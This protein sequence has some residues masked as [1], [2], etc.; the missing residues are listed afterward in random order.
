MTKPGHILLCLCLLLS[1]EHSLIASLNRYVQTAVNTDSEGLV[2]DSQGAVIHMLRSS[3]ADQ[4]TITKTDSEG[5]LVTGFGTGG[6][7]TLNFTPDAGI[8]SVTTV[9]AFG[10]TG[11]DRTQAS[12]IGL[13]PSNRILLAVNL[14][15]GGDRS[16][17]IIRLNGT[18]GQLDE[19]YGS[20]GVGIWSGISA[21]FKL[22]G[23]AIDTTGRAIIALWHQ[24]NIAEVR[25]FSANGV[26]EVVAFDIMSNVA[27]GLSI[28]VGSLNDIYIAGRSGANGFCI[29]LIQ[30]TFLVDASFGT[31]GAYT[32]NLGL[33]ETSFVYVTVAAG[34]IYLL[35]LHGNDTNINLRTLNSVGALTGNQ[36][37]IFPSAV[38]LKSAVRTANGKFYLG[39]TINSG[40]QTAFWSRFTPNLGNLD[41]DLT[42]ADNTDANRIANGIMRVPVTAGATVASGAGGLL[43]YNVTTNTVAVGFKQT[44][45]DATTV[46]FVRDFGT[47]ADHFLT[48]PETPIVPSA[49]TSAPRFQAQNSGKTDAGFNRNTFG[50]SNVVAIEDAGV[51]AN[52]SD[53]IISYLRSG[54]NF[55]VSKTNED[56]S[57]DTSFGSN[58]S[59]SQLIKI[60][61]TGSSTSTVA[62]TNF[63][64]LTTGKKSFIGYNL[65]GSDAYIYIAFQANL[66][67]GN[68]QIVVIRLHNTTGLLDS[69]FGT[70]GVA[71][72]ADA[73]FVHQLDALAVDS[74]GRVVV[75][76]YRE[77]SGSKFPVVYRFT[78][79]GTLDGAF[80]SSGVKNLSAVMAGVTDTVVARLDLKLDTS[81]NIYV[82]GKYAATSPYGLFGVKLNASDGAIDNG[83][84]SSGRFTTGLLT[85]LTTTSRV[86]ASIDEY[87]STDN[88]QLCSQVTGGVLAVQ[89]SLA[90]QAQLA[91]NNNNKTV[92]SIPNITK[93]NFVQ[94]NDAG[95]LSCAGTVTES[96]I[97]KVFFA[98][99]TKEGVLDTTYGDT[100]GAVK[101]GTTLFTATG[102]IIQDGGWF[103]IDTGDAAPIVWIE[104]DGGTRRLILE[105]IP[106]N[107][108]LDS[109]TPTTSTTLATD[110]VNHQQSYM[111]DSSRLYANLGIAR[112]LIELRKALDGDVS[113]HLT[114]TVKDRAV[115][116][117][118]EA[119]KIILQAKISSA[120]SNGLRSGFK[121][122]HKTGSMN[123][124]M[125]DKTKSTANFTSNEQAAIAPHIAVRMNLIFGQ[126]DTRKTN[127]TGEITSN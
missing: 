90:G 95:N 70:A 71:T 27:S 67:T 69:G 124:Q 6:V 46:Q 89:F 122:K 98:R 25:R 107:D 40:G 44:L 42:F 31:A 76:T 72:I 91:F 16:I 63:T 20:G 30:G 51:L 112:H 12:Y 13:D 65:Y 28:A 47:E 57:L 36:N 117:F 78:D 81:N 87:P 123:K 45:S 114:T 38:V 11:L 39:G 52:T 58:Y 93:L 59:G 110:L 29:K 77:D 119:I 116:L 102:G 49:A 96:G 23:L 43:A 4:F 22:Q 60:R 118:D 99:I 53:S 35:T 14:Q 113:P 74:T 55:I 104:Q 3:T 19:T 101:T 106:T 79:N 48:S 34:S 2:V 24:S 80:G 10:L 121:E 84:G 127:V 82:V 62:I 75:L 7:V 73:N 94:R 17:A 21:S 105:R 120:S 32:A 8:S 88:I 26:A 5:S 54:D 41:N 15:F 56:G 92:V 37:G 18:T 111:L 61:A 100:S 85:E 33:D 9:R 68:K 86:F 125:H 50:G 64:G 103:S 66:S 97:V 126:L 83:F 1:I 115:Q 108:D 109:T